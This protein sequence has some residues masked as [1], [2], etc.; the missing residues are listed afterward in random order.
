[1]PLETGVT[2]LQLD[3]SWPL[4][5]D[6]TNRGDDHLRLIKSIL[7]TQ[8][9]GVGG[10]GFDTPILATEQE[11]NWL[12][13]LTGNVQAQ[14]DSLGERL[15]SLE[16]TL[17]APPGTVL[18]F[19]QLT[20]PLGWTQDTS[21]NDA[22]FRVVSTSGGGSGGSDSPILNDKVPIHSHTASIDSAGEHVHEQN[23]IKDGASSWAGQPLAGPFLS[24]SSV[25][26]DPAGDHDHSVTVN[27]NS[28]SNW[29]PKY[30]DMIIASKD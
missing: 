2:L 3:E 8:F 27:A 5:G 4:G 18:T 28:G 10:N 16:A 7:K 21:N 30:I 11:I 24:G 25:F 6:P 15:D 22:M 13:G 17:N 20:P 12:A 26:T 23:L 14:F 9:P 19:Y 29:T 1:M